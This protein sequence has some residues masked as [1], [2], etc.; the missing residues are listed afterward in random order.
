[1]RK[2]HEAG[3]DASNEYAPKSMTD[4]VKRFF[5]HVIEGKIA[6]LSPQQRTVVLAESK[7]VIGVK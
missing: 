2:S 7:V 6:S 5:P 1:M 3:P 4:A